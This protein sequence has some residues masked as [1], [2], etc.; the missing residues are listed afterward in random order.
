MQIESYIVHAP[1]AQ[2]SG[3]AML[4]PTNSYDTFRGHRRGDQHPR[5]ASLAALRQFTFRPPVYFAYFLKK[6]LEISALLR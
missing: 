1:Q 6:V 5:V 2:F 3:R 4:A